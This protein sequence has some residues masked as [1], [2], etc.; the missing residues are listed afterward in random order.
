METLPK[1]IK[2]NLNDHEFAAWLRARNAV[3]N[4]TH[5]LNFVYWRNA[6]GAVVAIAE[7]DNATNTRETWITDDNESFTLDCELT[8]TFGGEANYCW[9]RQ[10]SIE[11]PQNITDL[12]LVRRAKKALGINGYSGKIYN[13]GDMWEFRPYGDNVV[14]FFTV[15]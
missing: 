13:H 1:I 4:F 11:L 10:E 2:V 7:Y 12:A 8:D 14:A 3:D 9:V 15:R 6:R 5:H